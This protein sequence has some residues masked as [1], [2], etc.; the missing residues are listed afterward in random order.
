MR[1][2]WNLF[3]RINLSQRTV[4]YQKIDDSKLFRQFIGGSGLG[5]KF[6]NEE[7]AANVNWN[8]PENIVSIMPGPFA[9]GPIPGSGTISVVTK[10]PMTN[11]AGSSQ[12]NG[13]FGA[14]LKTNGFD[15][16]VI[17]GVASDWKV[18]VISDGA[19]NLIDGNKYLGYDAISTGEAISKDLGEKNVSVYAIGPAGE[20]MV[21]FAC[22][23]GDAGHVAAHN[24]IGA[25]LGSKKLKAIAV[26]RGN[27]KVDFYDN[28][29]LKRI[30]KEMYNH[31]KTFD[32]GARSKWGTASHV[33]SLYRTG[34]LPIK[35]Y[36]TSKWTFYEKFTGQ[37]IRE[38]FE[39]KAKPCWACS[40]H[41]KY[42]T[43][44]EGIYKGFKAEEPE[45]EQFAAFGPLIGNPDTGAAV[46]LSD[47][48]DRLGMDC[49]EVGWLVAWLMECYE[50]GFLTKKD[51][52]GEELTW[53][54]VTAVASI[55][56]KIAKRQGIGDVLSEGV[57]RASK[58]IGS[59][60]DKR[61][62]YTLKGSSPRGHDH[63]G[64]W[65]ELLDTCLSN[66]G[67]IEASGGRID[68]TQPGLKPLENRFSPIEVSTLNAHINGRRM[69]EDCVSICRFTAESFELLVQALNAATG[70]NMTKTEAMNVGRRTINVLRQFNMKHGLKIENEW[71]SERYGSSPEDG[72]VKGISILPVFKE[73]RANYWKGMG[74]DENGKPLPETLENLGLEELK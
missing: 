22:L 40:L 8:D 54:N 53:G 14:Y 59:G 67:T 19:A 66:T 30:G 45:Y 34:Q 10:G 17:K 28:D 41:C 65:G 57:M 2:Y 43:V 16:L 72:P 5:A 6:L 25:V 73:M 42:T 24:G 70:W 35:N 38:K 1:G 64:R 55:L 32:G 12:A 58:M 51:L 62:V 33:E 48:N 21:R 13:F 52:D 46:M 31:A 61:A 9:G 3:A 23:V 60:L 20:N 18:L 44:T 7:V 36:T 68:V 39:H 71:P 37:Y 50:E 69:F 74:W 49:N 15:G 11:L 26:V 47:L 29:N 56:E 63:R 4:D 27:R